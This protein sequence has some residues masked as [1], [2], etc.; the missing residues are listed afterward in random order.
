MIYSEVMMDIIIHKDLKEI[1]NT[2]TTN[3]NQVPIIITI[4]KDNHIIQDIQY[5]IHMVIK[6]L[7]KENKLEDKNVNKKNNIEK[8]S[9]KMKEENKKPLIKL[10]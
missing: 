9:K 4:I 2:M 5:L 8:C 1:N 6:L 7:N 10:I 3:L